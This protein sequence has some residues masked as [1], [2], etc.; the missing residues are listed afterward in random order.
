MNEMKISDLI[1]VRQKQSESVPEYIQRFRE[2]RS[3]CYSLRISDSELADLAFQ[4]L[5]TPIK[6]KFA[7][8]EFE[9]LSQLLHKVSAHERHF[10]E[11]RNDR[12][13]KLIALVQ[14][15]SD[16]E[17]ADECDIGLVEWARNKQTVQCPWVKEVSERRQYGFDMNKADQ[18]FDL[19]LK[20]KQIKLP[21]EHVIPTAQEL[22]NRKYCKWHHSW[23]HHTNEC[24]VFRQQVQATIEQG[25]LTFGKAPMKIDHTPFSVNMVETEGKA[26][27]SPESQ[28]RPIT[29]AESHEQ[30]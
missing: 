2:V 16:E 8:S 7:T 13:K 28:P 4:G 29:K 12:F 1:V 11:Q 26:M 3:R 6:E 25:R 21:A 5:L 30:I 24:K 17:E 10:Q 18:I 27:A 15:A 14:W 9:S 23:S 20:E 22:R 19:L